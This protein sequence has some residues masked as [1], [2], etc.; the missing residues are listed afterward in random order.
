MRYLV[1]LPLGDRRGARFEDL[2]RD[3]DVTVGDCVLVDDLLV[4]VRY[5]VDAGE[6]GYDATLIC[7]P[8]EPD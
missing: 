7:T 5:A 6:D 2:E 8:D 1:V 3:G 4:R